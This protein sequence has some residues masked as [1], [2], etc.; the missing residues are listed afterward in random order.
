MPGAHGFQVAH[1]AG[2][3]D[4]RM[5]VNQQMDVIR[6]AVELQQ[7]TPPAFAHARHLFA[8][9]RQHLRGQAT[10]PVLGDKDNMK[11]Q[12]ESRVATGFERLCLHQCMCNSMIN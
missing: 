11:L 1:H 4:G 2:E 6:F 3:I 7:C 5:A 9:L 12:P 10:M 8:H